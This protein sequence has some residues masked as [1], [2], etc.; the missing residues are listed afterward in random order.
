MPLW[1]LAWRQTRG[2]GPLVFVAS[3]GLL[4]TVTLFGAG[5][6]YLN[7]VERLAFQGFLEQ[8]GNDL[9]LQ[10]YTAY[11]SFSPREY[12]PTREKIL[13]AAEDNLGEA[14]DRRGIYAV[15]YFIRTAFTQ[16]E[17]ENAVTTLTFRTA[18]DD[19]V[20]VVEGRAARYTTE[21]PIEV[22]LG[23]QAADR[24]GLEV[25]QQ[26]HLNSNLPP[27]SQPFDA[28]MVGIVAPI[29]AEDPYW[30]GVGGLFYQRLDAARNDAGRWMIS[31]FLPIETLVNRIG[32]ETPAQL[33]AVNDVLYLDPDVLLDMGAENVEEALAR[34]EG[35]LSTDVPRAT[36]ISRLATQTPGFRDE[37]ARSQM[38]LIILLIVV[39]ATLLYALAMIAVTVSRQQEGGVALLRSR[40]ASIART[41]MLILFWTLGI[42]VVGMALVPLIAHAMVRSLGYVGAWRAVLDGAPLSPAPLLPAAPWLLLGALLA[43]LI[44]VLPIVGVSRIPVAVLQSVRSRPANT[45]WFRRAFIDVLVLAVAAAVLWQLQVRGIEG[46]GVV[47]QG[48]E[49]PS[50]DRA[51]LIVPILTIGAGLL[52]YYRFLPIAVG[53]AAAIARAYGRLPVEMALERINRASAPAAVLGGLLFLVGALGVFAATFGGTLD[54]AAADH[55]TFTAGK[56]ARIDRFEGF[57]G[58]SISAVNAEFESIDGVEDA[59]AAYSTYAGIG[60]LQVGTLVPLMGVD[61]A[62]IGGLVDFRD[63]FAETPIEE[64]LINLALVNESTVSQRI[65]PDG[66]ESVGIWVKPEFAQGN[67]F[68][69]LQIV[70]GLGRQDTYSLGALDF[71]EWRFLDKELGRGDRP[72][73]PGPYTVSGIIIY[74]PVQGATGTPGSMELDDLTAIGASGERLVVENFSRAGD[75][76]P[77][78]VSGQR[79]DVIQAGRTEPGHQGVLQFEWGRETRDGLRGIYVSPGSTAVPILAS[80]DLLAVR[81]WS[82]GNLSAIHVSGRVVPVRVVG[83]IREFPTIEA[84]SAGFLIANGQTLLNH[85]NAVSVTNEAQPNRVFLGL[86]DDPESRAAVFERIEN[87]DRLQGTVIDRIE[88]QEEMQRSP[89]ASAGWRGMTVLAL[90]AAIAALALGVAGHA[91]GITSGRAHEMAVLRA[92]GLPRRT[93]IIAFSIEY[94]TIVAPAAIFGVVVGLYVSWIL[95]PRFQGVAGVEQ[96]PSLVLAPDWRIIGLLMAIIGIAGASIAATLWRTY[97]SQRVASVIRAAEA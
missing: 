41:V 51:I 37:V 45:L 29:D 23:K 3:L 58:A 40:G 15:S 2:N 9:D 6:L 8:Q 96:V 87:K 35:R 12:E 71:A 73:P 44:V 91:A 10:L 19:H 94:V 79:R 49:G 92:V 48:D 26:F 77:L 34:L 16:P 89:L 28:V 64:L 25:G 47:V 31:M 1:G 55:A 36:F 13:A 22:V 24:I 38:P 52:I 95:V 67:R 93:A 80:E 5:P 42:L 56:D 33:G 84:G 30:F 62:T 90:A 18:F 46:G 4:L 39:G 81:G 75:W 74:E 7:T 83:N 69:W 82:V 68:L 66:T 72:P 17:G 43:A 76:L 70:D 63:D 59:S 32:M 97:L 11:S 54:R 78:L 53:I 88:L 21:G 86:P 20:R 85:M 50:I 61:P 57:A 27:P 60:S 14:L 65:I